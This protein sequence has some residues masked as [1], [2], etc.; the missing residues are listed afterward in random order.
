M[1]GSITST[2]GNVSIVIFDYKNK[3]ICTLK[4]GL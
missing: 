3:S 4:S 1:L 2:L